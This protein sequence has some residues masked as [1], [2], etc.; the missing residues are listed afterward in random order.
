MLVLLVVL[1]EAVELAEL[2]EAVELA[3]L[4][5]ILVLHRWELFPKVVDGG[6]G[7]PV[8]LI[9]QVITVG[10]EVLVEL[11][12][13]EVLVELE[14][15]EEQEVLAVKVR[16]GQKIV[17]VIFRHVSIQTQILGA[18]VLL[19]LVVRVVIPEVEDLVEELVQGQV[20]TVA[21]Q[22]LALIA[23]PHG[24]KVTQEQQE[25]LEEL[26]VEVQPVVVEEQQLP[27]V[28]MD[29]QGLV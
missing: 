19:V 24:V 4:E 13:L 11:A 28:H 9:N 8:G 10:L 18:E 20:H 12:E 14:V 23:V 29:P 26:E 21:G 15:P 17:L 6:V 5:V 27:A 7:T 1:E 2:E 22:L 25:I 16:D 3:E